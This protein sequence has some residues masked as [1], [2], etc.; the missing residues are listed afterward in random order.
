MD[1]YTVGEHGQTELN[2]PIGLNEILYPE[3]VSEQDA[4]VK[5]ALAYEKSAL[6]S[7]EGYIANLDKSKEEFLTPLASQ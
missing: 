5:S 1:K 6:K 7:R 2:D 4:V 3:V